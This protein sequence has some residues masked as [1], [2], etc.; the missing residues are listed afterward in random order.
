MWTPSR[1]T[2][3]GGLGRGS[4][5]LDSFFPFDPYLLRRSH[6]YVAS[7]YNSWKVRTSDTIPVF[8]YKEAFL[9]FFWG[10]DI[11]LIVCRVYLRT[12]AQGCTVNVI[13]EG[14]GYDSQFSVVFPYPSFS[15]PSPPHSAYMHTNVDASFNVFFKPNHPPQTATLLTVTCNKHQRNDDNSFQPHRIKKS[16]QHP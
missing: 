14:H 3:A 16:P 8:V 6:V 7:M 5:P 11:V 1:V 10:G 9:F 13:H 4:D 12:L 15:A 2:K